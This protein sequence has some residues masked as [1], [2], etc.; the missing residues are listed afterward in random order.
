MDRIEVEHLRLLPEL[1]SDLYE[2]RRLTLDREALREID[3]TLAGLQLHQNRLAHKLLQAL[4]SPAEVSTFRVKALQSQ[5]D[6]ETLA[7]EATKAS[8][9]L[10]VIQQCR[11]DRR[12]ARLG[13][14]RR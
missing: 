7:A 6:D 10:R 5:W 14:G 4:P 11:Q 13:S 3:Q 12:L 2:C 1:I 8:M 9:G